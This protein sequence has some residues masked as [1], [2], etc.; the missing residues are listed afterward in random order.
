M[1][2]LTCTTARW[3]SVYGATHEMHKAFGDAM[4]EHGTFHEAFLAATRA[5]P[6]S[7]GSDA[8]AVKLVS[9]LGTTIE[10]EDA[11]EL[12]LQRNG[13]FDCAYVAAVLAAPEIPFGAP[14]SNAPRHAQQKVVLTRRNLHTLLSKLDRAA[15]G[16]TTACSL[17]KRDYLHPTHP[18]SMESIMVHAVEDAAYYT[19]REAGRMHPR[20]EN[21]LLELAEAKRH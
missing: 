11:Y 8:S 9:L 17:I 19:D 7:L 1:D 13:S 12:A 5:T 18:Q 6:A 14:H 21:T 4:R 16:E 2:Q 20:D 15:A 10:M 3:V